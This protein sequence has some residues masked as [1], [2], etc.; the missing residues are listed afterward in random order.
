MIRELGNDLRF[1]FVPPPS[2]NAP[3]D[4]DNSGIQEGMSGLMNADNVDGV[5]EKIR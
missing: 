5:R 4:A 2:R 3:M 1:P